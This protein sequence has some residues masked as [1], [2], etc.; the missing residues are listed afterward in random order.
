M[1]GGFVPDLVR[2]RVGPVRQPRGGLGE[3][4][5]R[6]L[7][8]AEVR[9]LAPRG[10]E[11]DALAALAQ[12]S[13]SRVWMSTQTLQPLIWL[14]RSVT[15]ASVASG[16]PACFAEAASCWAASSAPGTDSAGFWILAWVMVFLLGCECGVVDRSPCQDAAG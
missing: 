8:V 4:E 3:R 14:A 2:H 13:S 5:R 12:C 7:G 6:T 15:I 11:V 16:I 1:A 10:D 9:G